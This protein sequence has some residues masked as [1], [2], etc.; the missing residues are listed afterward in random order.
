MSQPD[1]AMDDDKQDALARFSETRRIEAERSEI[2]P[3]ASRHL[4]R[5]SI[6]ICLA[7]VGVSVLLLWRAEL[8]VIVTT[9]GQIMPE[10]A[11]V[12]LQA[13]ADGVIAEAP[14]GLGDVILSGQTITRLGGAVAEAELDALDRSIAGKTE[15]REGLSNEVIALETLIGDFAALD[16]ETHDMTPY[17]A[18]VA[19][20]QTLRL[21]RQDVVR[22]AR[23][24]GKEFAQIR[25][26]SDARILALRRTQ[27]VRQSN[28]DRARVD[29]TTSLESEALW[30]DQL[31]NVEQLIA[32]GLADR[33]QA[34]DIREQALT[35]ASSANVQR[36]KIGA[37]EL[38]ISQADLKISEIMIEVDNEGARRAFELDEA[39]R[40]LS[41]GR[42]AIFSR[43][44]ELRT[45]LQ[46]L[47]VDIAGLS[48]QR[49]LRK[50]KADALVIRAP[51]AGTVAELTHPSPGARVVRGEVLVRIVPEGVENIVQVEL[52]S[53][54]AGKVKPGQKAVI[55]LDAYPYYRFGTT[56]AEVLSVFPKPGARTFVVR[57]RLDRQTVQ[58]NGLEQGITV[59]LEATAEIVAERRSLLALVF[60]RGAKVFSS[61]AGDANATNAGAEG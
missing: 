23:L 56:P 55:K 38:E 27:A 39:Y 60:D 11:L 15:R 7:V 46:A 8:D 30:Q 61:V 50:E 35:A 10:R 16:T 25:D 31:A 24:E 6:Y 28:L 9:R 36:E 48:D 33:A 53:S 52:S 47:D 59:G 13:P 43:L 49:R 54:D 34:L 44:A 51:L 45:R 26:N 58:V 12:T 22:K 1:E 5:A 14:V 19:L 29:L 32:R 4:V 57:L 17:G 37:L 21:A 2:I 42:A 41:A 40:A 3:P 18:S 20:V